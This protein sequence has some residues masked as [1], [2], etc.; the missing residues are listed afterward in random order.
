MQ[1]CISIHL[2]WIYEPV[3]E[4]P[5]DEIS[6]HA[7][8][9]HSVTMSLFMSEFI[10]TMASFS[11][12]T[13]TTT[14]ATVYYHH[15]VCLHAQ[16][17]CVRVGF[18][19]CWDWDKYNFIETHSLLYIRMMFTWTWLM[20]KM[21]MFW[22]LVLGE[23]RVHSSFVTGE[24]ELLY[25]SVPIIHPTWKLDLYRFVADSSQMTWTTL[26][27]GFPKPILVSNQLSKVNS[28]TTCIMFQELYVG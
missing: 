10:F 17:N 9:S 6:C 2:C 11:W 19:W 14:T 8:N 3:W 13:T 25:T 18:Q 27:R 23:V 28:C 21:Y 24:N 22:P 15:V 4:R 5:S 1:A 26:I 20:A 7:T 16:I 12:T